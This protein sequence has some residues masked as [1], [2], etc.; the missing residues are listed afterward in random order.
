MITEKER[1]LARLK[2]HAREAKKKITWIVDQLTDPAFC[3]GFADGKLAAMLNLP[4]DPPN[5]TKADPHTAHQYLRGWLD[6]WQTKIEDGYKPTVKPP[7]PT[8]P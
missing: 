7:K 4:Y 8:R 3:L 1:E 5:F 6:G 2:R